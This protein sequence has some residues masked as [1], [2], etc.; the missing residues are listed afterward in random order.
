MQTC[1]KCNGKNLGCEY[2]PDTDTVEQRCY[3]CHY[4]E[5]LPPGHEDLKP[6]R[7]TISLGHKYTLAGGFVCELTDDEHNEWGRECLGMPEYV[8][9][10]GEEADLQRTIHSPNSTWDHLCDVVDDLIAARL[11]MFNAAEAWYRKLRKVDG[12]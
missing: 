12:E 10:E 4:A 5:S 8:R 6:R 7:R 2:K 11:A 9:L 1:P 3:N